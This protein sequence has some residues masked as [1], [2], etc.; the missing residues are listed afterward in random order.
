ME[1]IPDELFYP[2]TAE[3]I[4]LLL[5]TGL[6]PSDRKEVHLSKTAENAL[7]AGRHRAGRPFLIRI[8]AAGAIGDGYLIKQAG[9]TVYTTREVP[10]RFL[11]A[12]EELNEELRVKYDE[13]EMATVGEG[14]G[15]ASSQREGAEDGSGEMKG[16]GGDEQPEEGGEGGEE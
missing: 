1:D 2:A 4:E 8:D 7:E 6:K 15:E 12:M 10:D 5:E 14:G 11:S 9:T 13:E 16:V 3:E